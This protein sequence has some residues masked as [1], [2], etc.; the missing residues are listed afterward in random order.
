MKESKFIDQNKAKWLSFERL[1]RADAKDPDK[2]SD[3]FIQIT[4][5]L[6]YARTFY[7]N[8][9]IRVYLNNICQQLFYLIN[10]SH[11]RTSK[12][13]FINF[14][15]Y[16]LPT[17]SY[18]SRKELLTSLI[19]FLMSVTIG[20][21]SSIHD[22]EFF[23]TILGEDYVTMTVENIESGDPMAVYKKMNEMDMFF[24][25]TLNNLLVSVKTF[26]LGLLWAIGSIIILI[27]NGI[28]VGTFQYFFIEKGLFAE[29]FLTIWMHGAIEISSIVIAG[30]AGI[31]LGKG[32][33]PGSFSRLQSF[34]IAAKKGTKLFLG[35]V[36]LIVMAAIIES[37]LTRYTDIPDALRL[38]FI[39]LSFAFIFFYFWWYPRFVVKS[40]KGY[41]QET[42]DLQNT[43]DLNIRYPDQIK[44]GG[45]VLR[46]SFLFYRKHFK[47]LISINFYF[48][49]VYLIVA[50]VIVYPSIDSYGFFNNYF[51]WMTKLSDQFF[52]YEEKPILLLINAVFFSVHSA[53]IVRIIFKEINGYLPNRG[54]MLIFVAYHLLFSI[55]LNS[56]DLVSSGFYF[57]ASFLVSPLI[58][59]FLF[60]L[61]QEGKSA[62]GKL[63][64]RVR[65]LIKQKYG[66]V[67]G[68][69]FFVYLIS[70]VGYFFLSSPFPLFYMDFINWNIQLEYETMNMIV[71]FLNSFITIFIN[72]LTVPLF[73]MGI[74]L[75]YFTLL[76][77]QEANG[78]KSQVQK[79]AS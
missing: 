54:I 58:S 50:G 39:V 71:F 45:E 68:V 14:W 18:N 1:L 43:A 74:S 41:S 53:F 26:L 70:I 76:E 34:Q 77:I 79:F 4:D 24:G 67:I 55:I 16:E 59:L 65:F 20:I 2:L 44:T 11:K 33:S 27:Y 32:I 73:L 19:I 29:S 7:N 6:S 46:D 52:S 64:R 35:I 12:K 21:I 23:R 48:S 36:P 22:P 47:S 28:M 72:L 38:V 8:R 42:S 60:I 56:L 31:V 62:L 49:I 10:K 75:C 37:F 63:M 57:I 78:L 9:S 40:G 30:A 5:D 25:I 51:D 17:I 15:K 13:S 61:I 3:F 69:V 66:Y